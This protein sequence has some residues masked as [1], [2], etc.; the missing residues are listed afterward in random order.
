M[1]T[2]PRWLRVQELFETAGQWPR[3]ERS[4]RLAAIETDE[5]LRTEVLQLLT[6]SDEESRASHP[7][8]PPSAPLPE[9]IG[10][11]RILALAGAGGRGLVYRGVVETAG[12]EQTVAIKVMREHLIAPEDLDRFEREQRA[13]LA[14]NHPGIARFLAA[15]WDDS[16][17]PYLA[18]EW[19]EGE[20]IDRYVDRVRAPTE[21]RVR[22]MLDLLDTLQS[23]HTNLIVHPDLKP[24]NVLV[25]ETGRVR[26]LDFGAAKLLADGDATATRQLTPLYSSPERLRGETVTTACDIYSAGLLLHHLLS[27]RLPFRDSSSIAALGERA[28]GL[29][30]PEI[31]TGNAELDAVV[32]KALRFEPRD[33]YTTAADFA[34]DLRAFLESRPVTARP[35]T[36]WYRLGRFAARNRALVAVSAAATIGLASLAGY[37]L[38]QQRQRNVEAA[39]TEKVASFLRWLI[40]SSAVPGSG[41][42]DMTVVEMVQRGAKRLT[43]DAAMPA[44]V[45]SGIQADFAYLT[46]EFGRE[47]LAEPIARD[48]LAKADASGDAEARLRSRGTLAATLMRRGECAAALDLFRAGDPVLEQNRSRIGP[49]AQAEYLAARAS[50][51][52]QCEAQPARA[53]AALEQA[54]AAAATAEPVFRAGLLLNYSLMLTRAGRAEDARAAADQGLAVAQSHPDGRYFQVAILRIRSQNHAAAGRA[55]EALADIREAARLGPGVVNPFEEIRLRTLLAGRTVDAGQPGEAARIAR[56]ALAEARRRHEAVGPSFWMIVADA[57]EVL[58]KTRN[59]EESEALYREADALTDGKMPRTW[60]G[61]RLF[62]A[63]ECALP[64]GPRRAA[65]LAFEARDAYGDLLPANSKRR[66]RIEEILRAK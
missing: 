16:G 34:A 51:A 22:V 48:A 15:G 59:C 7:A 52:E 5:Q 1:P 3:D 25:D 39:R 42:P 56:E 20:P 61:N 49:V 28:A 21:E 43:E 57:A 31:A 46:R 38:Q 55:A 27:G 41:R 6:A 65:Q 60:R 66:A 12:A 62:F 32:G 53:V 37:A 26:V 11:Y 19:V 64:A 24:S 13:L 33:R 30:A 35:P 10:P 63:A 2:D 40:T 17:R 23:A 36:L 14:L 45:A 58:A 4:S 50:A 47:D 29:A 9:K 18:M 54:L 8:P 44:D